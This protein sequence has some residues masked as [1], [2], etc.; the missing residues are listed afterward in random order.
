MS[1]MSLSSSCAPFRASFKSLTG[2]T[3]RHTPSSD[4]DMQLLSGIQY[5][6]KRF[7]KSA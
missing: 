6:S 2:S 3:S 1:Y 5:G 7:G 4:F